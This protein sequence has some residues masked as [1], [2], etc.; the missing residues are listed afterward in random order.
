MVVLAEHSRADNY[1]DAV[2]LSPGFEIRIPFPAIEIS[3][4]HSGSK[5]HILAYGDAVLDPKFQDF[6]EFPTRRKRDQHDEIVRD[7]QRH[8]IPIPE[9][10]D[11][12]RGRLPDGSFARPRKWMSSRTLIA[13]AVAKAT[14]LDLDRAKALFMDGYDP[15]ARLVNRTREQTYNSLANYL[16]T[17]PVI[18]IIRAIGAIP[19]LAHPWWEFPSGKMT[20]NLMIQQLSEMCAA[21][22][23]GIESR[24]YHYLPTEVPESVD[25]AAIF[26]LLEFAGSDYHGNGKSDLG[27]VGLTEQEFEAIYEAVKGCKPLP[28]KPRYQAV[29]FDSIGALVGGDGMAK[30]DARH[31]FPGIS[32]LGVRSFMDGPAKLP[33]EIAQYFEHLESAPRAEALRVRSS[34]VSVKNARIEPELPIADPESPSAAS[35]MAVLHLL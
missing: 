16:P 4:V 31:L 10:D 23:V 18:K 32:L 21:G 2:A 20:T 28:A 29:V 27:V 17:L 1:Y 30:A 33:D 26:G 22:L 11:I 12:M 5:H 19:V 14:G 34:P 24:S 9:P 6:A 13:Q 8:G 3:T 7:L 15:D 25:L 35:L